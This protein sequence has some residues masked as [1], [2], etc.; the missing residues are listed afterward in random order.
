M[1]AR[2]RSKTSGTKKHACSMGSLILLS[3]ETT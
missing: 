3:G 2:E 1:A